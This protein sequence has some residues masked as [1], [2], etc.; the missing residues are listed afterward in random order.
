[1]KKE[2]MLFLFCFVFLGMIL[3][4]AHVIIADG[5]E[6]NNSGTEHVSAD[7]NN[8]DNGRGEIEREDVTDENGNNISIEVRHQETEDGN[9][10]VRETDFEDENGNNITIINR[11]EVSGNNSNGEFNNGEFDFNGVK[12][13]SDV[14]L[15]QSFENNKTEIKAEVGNKNE[16]IKIMPDEASQIALKA[17]ADN[18]FV[19][20]LIVV[21]Q[22]NEVKVVYSADLNQS[23]RILGLL[24][25]DV[26]SKALIDGQT[27]NVTDLNQPWWG[28]LVFGKHSA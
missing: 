13:K 28:F 2:L 16:T 27:G 20:K 7:G 3:N 19:L 5:R 1:M 25:V 26:L 10:T 23:G 14:K 11:N 18:G 6:N 24:P 22:G 8:G 9:L 12:L 21:G 4:Y 15:E 17:L